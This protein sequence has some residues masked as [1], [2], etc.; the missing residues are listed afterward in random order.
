MPASPP[1]PSQPIR[2]VSPSRYLQEGDSWDLRLDA[3]ATL[4]RSNGSGN[5]DGE[6]LSFISGGIGKVDSTSA[7]GLQLD[8]A[9]PGWLSDSR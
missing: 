6:G 9:L 7:D 3:L 8:D 2:Y 1:G 4:L 5:I